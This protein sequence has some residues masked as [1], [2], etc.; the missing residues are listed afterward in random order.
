MYKTVFISIKVTTHLFFICS[1]ISACQ[2]GK[3]GRPEPSEVPVQETHETSDSEK[4]KPRKLTDKMARGF[5]KEYGQSNQSTQAVIHTPMGDI[6]VKLYEDTP[7]HRAN[8]LYLTEQ[9]YYND[10]WFHRVSA[11]HVIQAG[12]T[13][14]RATVKKRARLG[15]YHLPYESGAGHLHQRGAWPLLAAIK[16][17]PIENRIPTSFTSDWARPTHQ[18]GL[19]CWLKKRV[20]KFLNDS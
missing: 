8:F 13:D 16:I 17:I 5:L 10:T 19:N 15:D 7:L 1:F 20:L 12:N 14:E 3:P 6:R 2:S 18:A 4:K 11:G 9:G